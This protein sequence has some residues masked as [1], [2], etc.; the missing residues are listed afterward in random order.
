MKLYSDTSIPSPHPTRAGWLCVPVPGGGY[1]EWEAG[2]KPSIQPG[3][4]D[5]PLLHFSDG[6]LHWLTIGERLTL[7]LGLTNAEKLERKLR[8]NLTR[9]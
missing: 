3:H 8:P 2:H 5:G 9:R 4:I 1:I 6:Q 7:T